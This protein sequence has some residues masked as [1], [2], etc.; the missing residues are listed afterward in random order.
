MYSHSEGQSDICE[1][2]D[3]YLQP[4]YSNLSQSTYVKWEIY[5][6]SVSILASLDPQSTAHSPA[7]RL[8]PA[9]TVH[10]STTTRQAR[11]G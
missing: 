11:V 8:F 3:I 2:G 5:L 6:P 1:L 4:V 9:I 10:H 7:V